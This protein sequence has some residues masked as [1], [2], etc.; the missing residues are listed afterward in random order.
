MGVDFEQAQVLHL[1][2][3]TLPHILAALEAHLTT[4]GVE[5]YV[6]PTLFEARSVSPQDGPLPDKLEVKYRL[7]SG[8]DETV[9]AVLLGEAAGQAWYAFSEP[10]E[11]FGMTC[12]ALVKL[13]W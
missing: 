9:Q 3:E 4:C 2:L 10:H 6:V 5:G 8:E 12:I 7:T 1:R 13:A 11:H